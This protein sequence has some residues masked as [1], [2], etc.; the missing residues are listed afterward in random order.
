[1]QRQRHSTGSVRKQRNTWIGMWYVDGKRQSRV[2]GYVSEM[3]KTKAKQEVA[4]IAAAE[5]GNDNSSLARPACFYALR[6]ESDRCVIDAGR[7]G[8]FRLARKFGQL[9]RIPF[10]VLGTLA[11]TNQA[12]PFA[13]H[14][15]GAP[16]MPSL[17]GYRCMI[18]K[19][20]LQHIQ[21]LFFAPFDLPPMMIRRLACHFDELYFQYRDTAGSI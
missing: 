14:R 3:T 15:C 20:C 2:V 16:A 17:G 11:Q 7:A 1:M 4:K 19:S 21:G 6:K 10:T 13:R 18:L 8:L 5:P 9:C 12:L